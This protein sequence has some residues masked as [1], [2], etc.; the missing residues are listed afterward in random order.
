MPLPAEHRSR[1]EADGPHLHVTAMSALAILIF[2][3]AITPGPNNAVLV[4]CG[5]AQG[6][7]LGMRACLGIAMGGCVM[8]AVVWAALGA[9]TS[10]TGE[11]LRWLS[12]LGAAVLLK[13]AWTLWRVEPTSDASLPPSPHTGFWAMARFQLVNPKAWSFLASLA[14]MGYAAGQGAQ[15]FVA[16][17]VMFAGISLLCSLVWLA[18]GQALRHWLSQPRRMQH[19]NRVMACLLLAM[20]VYLPIQSW[21][22]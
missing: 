22:T 18:A 7:R 14:A 21:T 19:F 6:W 10:G 16:M 17:L 12:L 2:V 8:L 11:A 4:H 15:G 5:A 9:A 13:M 20:A 1:W 3:S